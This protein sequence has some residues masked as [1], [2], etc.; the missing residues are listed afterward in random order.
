M[1]NVTLLIAAGVVWFLFFRPSSKPKD[2]KKGGDKK[3]GD[4]K[5]G[6]KH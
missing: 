6:G 5:G 2:D 1:E 4:K 3:G